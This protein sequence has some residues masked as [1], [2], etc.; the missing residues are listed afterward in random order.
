MSVDLS[1]YNITL[2]QGD[3]FSLNYLYKG[4]NNIGINLDPL[5]DGVEYTAS[6]Q[7]RRSKYTDKLVGEITEASYPRGSWGRTGDFFPDFTSSYGKVGSH[8]GGIIL[9]QGGT[10]GAISIII[11]SDITN[12]LPFGR[13]VYDLQLTNTI[14]GNRSTLLS[15]DFNVI[16]RGSVV[17]SPIIHYGGDRFKL[18]FEYKNS[19][20][21]NASLAGYSAEM[22]IMKSPNFGISGGSGPSIHCRAF[23]G[24]PLGVDGRTYGFY[25]GSAVGAFVG[26]TSGGIKT[27]YGGKKLSNK[28]YEKYYKGMI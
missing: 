19:S 15:G 10:A 7:I 8:T 22:H 16:D 11:D 13:N 18:E 20:G 9:N 24:Y 25:A 23:E 6:M 3:T 21:V 5:G 4:A 27:E 1:S 17:D 26:T 2:I 28:S 12:F 14:N